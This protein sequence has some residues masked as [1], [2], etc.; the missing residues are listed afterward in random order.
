[1][2]EESKTEQRRFDG[3]WIPSELWLSKDLTIGEKVMI[4]EINSLDTKDRGCFAGNKHFAELFGFST[5]RVQQIIGRLKEKGMVSVNVEAATG[6]RTIR[7]VRSP[8]SPMKNIS[9]PH[10]EYFT[11]PM[12]N[13]SP[14]ERQ[15][16]KDNEN[17]SASPKTDDALYAVFS[18]KIWPHYPRRQYKQAAWLKFRRTLKKPGVT[19]EALEAAVRNYAATREGKDREYTMHGSTF[20][21]PQARYEDYVQKPLEEDFSPDMSWREMQA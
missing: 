3:I 2:S 17:T 9:P 19:V 20:F 11:P 18:E 21:G 6:E 14:R 7:I 1:M 16:E 4:A 12:K 15:S 10:E 5:R 13:I 8:I